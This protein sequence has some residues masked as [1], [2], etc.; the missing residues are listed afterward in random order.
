MPDYEQH[1]F[2][3]VP[4]Y[5]LVDGQITWKEYIAALSPEELAKQRAYDRNRVKRWYEQNKE[6]KKEYCRERAKQ[7]VVC[8]CGKEISKA[9]LSSHLNTLSHKTEIEKKSKP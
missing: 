1:E 6:R 4:S 9:Y 5:A 7:R 2:I 3:D 8:D